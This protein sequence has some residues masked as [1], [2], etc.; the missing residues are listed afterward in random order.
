MT[1]AAVQILLLAHE[2]GRVV[3]LGNLW[4]CSINF[5]MLAVNNLYEL[6]QLSLF[7]NINA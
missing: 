2:N 3:T 6:R 1:T 7:P 4:N 5:K